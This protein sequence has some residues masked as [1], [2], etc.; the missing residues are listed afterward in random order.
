MRRGFTL[1]ELL[2]VIAIIAILAAI[3]FPVFAKAREKARQASCQSNLKQIGLAIVMY[4]TDYDGRMPYMIRGQ[5]WPPGEVDDW[6]NGQ[7]TMSSTGWWTWWLAVQPYVK[8]TQIFE[9]PSEAVPMS[10]PGGCWRPFR[11]GNYGAQYGNRG[12]PWN[13]VKEAEVE[14][15]AG[16]IIVSD[17]CGRPFTCYRTANCPHGAW[18]PDATVPPGYGWRYRHNDGCNHLYFDGHVKWKRSIQQR[19]LTRYYD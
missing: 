1:I 6:G 17:S 14:D 7:P 8:N 11:W 13:A 18:N 19:E 2:V 5:H 3:L 9:C 4:R 10:R 15:V 16:T 12:R